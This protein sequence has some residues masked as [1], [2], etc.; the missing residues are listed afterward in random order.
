METLYKKQP[1]IK[2]FIGY[3]LF[4]TKMSTIKEQTLLVIYS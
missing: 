3:K 1:K 2:K 4:I